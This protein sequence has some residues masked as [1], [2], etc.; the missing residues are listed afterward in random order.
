MKSIIF[1]IAILLVLFIVGLIFRKKHTREIERLEKKKLQIQHYPIFEELTK[2]KNLNMNGQTEELFERWR[3]KWTEVVDVDI[4]KIDSMLFDAEEFIDRFKFKKA[5][6]IEKEIEE[7]LNKCDKIKNEI[8]DEL[9]ELIGSEEK[10]RIEMEQL[11][12]QYRSAR[13]TLLAHQ[14]SFGPALANLEKLL[15]EF[16]RKFEEY[17]KLTEEGNYLNAR[18]IV[19]YLNEKSKKLN[20]LINE[21]PGLLAEIQ[22]KIPAS[23]HELRTGQREMEEQSYYLK[24]LELTENL[25]QIEEEL[26]KL[27]E[28]LAKLNV[29]YV[30][31]RIEEIN[32]EIDNFYDLLEKEVYAKNY[33]D[34]NCDRTYKTLNEVLKT[35]R[36][37]STEAEYVQSSYRLPKEEAEIPKIGLKQLEV[38]QKRF[39]LLLSRVQGEKSAYSSLQ[40]ELMEISSEIERIQEEQEEFSNR[41]K[42]L[43]IDENKARAKLQS[44]KKMLQDTDRMLHKANIPGIPEE[45]DAR[46]EEAEEQLFLVMQSLQEVPLNMKQVNS[47]LDQAEKCIQDVQ[48][49]AKEM[50]ENVMLTERIIQYGNRY[51]SNPQVH[52]LLLQAEESFHKFRYVKALE[53]AAEAVEMAEPG[54]IKRLEELV[55]EEMFEKAKQ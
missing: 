52:E 6:V 34:K 33:V 50:I 29:G 45:M 3:N 53:L 19:L 36:E 18:E 25:E 15:E 26:K 24:H 49:H 31:S 5:S 46:L 28:E 23:I 32:D 16:P 14:Y 22:T 7:Y 47:N 55:Q 51:R 17:E 4:I 8:L 12:E 41:L 43:R 37:V 10:N 54:A 35:A 1:V 44:L 21:I 11:K 13:K 39:E 2:V 40:E 27:E 30:A 42:N 9:D 38:I 48:K 20:E